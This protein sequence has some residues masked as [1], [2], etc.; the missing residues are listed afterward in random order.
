[1][2]T[3]LNSRTRTWCCCWMWTRRSAPSGSGWDG[4]AAPMPATSRWISCGGCG[5]PPP[6]ST[7][8]APPP[9]ARAAPPVPA[10]ARG[11]ARAKRCSL[12][13]ELRSGASRSDRLL[14][15]RREGEPEG[16]A[17]ARTALDPDLASVGLHQGLADAQPQPGAAGPAGGRGIELGEGAK[18]ARQ[19]LL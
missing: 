9:G 16:A 17:L 12:P 8:P 3:R 13:P 19:I 2:A 6:P 5:S 4:K 18:Q 15:G 7:R 11:G 10:P 1:P 14:H